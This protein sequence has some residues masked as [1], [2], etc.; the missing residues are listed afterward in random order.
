MAN[1]I[2]VAEKAEIEPGTGK[3]L[4]VAGTP[5]ALFN[6]DGDYFAIHNTCLHRQGPLGEGQ[7][8]GNVVTCPLHGWQYDV[9]TGQA[10][11]NPSICVAKYEVKVEGEN[12]FVSEH[13]VQG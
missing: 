6:V 1:F 10:V 8:S 9:R 13:P 4:D 2:K 7:L 12:V 11:Q 5:V 3:T